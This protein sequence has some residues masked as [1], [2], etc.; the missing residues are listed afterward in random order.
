MA[1]LEVDKLTMR[2]GGLTAISQVD[3]RVEP[4]QIVSVIGPNGAGKTTVFNVITGIYEPSEGNIKLNGKEEGL[5]V[6]GRRL[7]AWLLMGLATGLVVMLFSV[8]ID[9]LWKAT[10]RRNMEDPQKFAWS[11]AWHDFKAYLLGGLDLEKQRGRWRV[12]AA[13]GDPV[14]AT[15]KTEQ[16]ARE[17]L[18]RLESIL[19]LGKFRDH[20]HEFQG[21][22]QV[23]KAMNG[24]IL[25]EYPS[26]EAAE[27]ELQMLAEVQQEQIG[28]RRVA[29]FSFLGGTLLGSMAGFVYWRQTRRTPEVIALA[30]IA[31][32]F[33][34]IRLFQNMSVLENVLTGRD[35]YFKS[36]LWGMVRGALGLRGEERAAVTESL[37]LLTFVGLARKANELAKNLPYGDQRRLEIARALATRPKLLLLDE[38]AAGMNPAE[39]GSLMALIGKIR[40][41]GITILLIE[42]HMSLVMAISDRIAV[43]DHGVKIAEG[44][45]EEV[46][47][48]PKVI[49]AY[50]GKEETE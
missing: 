19:D 3:L 23:L 34:N 17:S 39:T 42:H 45:P 13:D 14:L 36:G 8:N 29:L 4:G 28:R 31:R 1:L 24:P 49:A 10:I 30:G 33:Q 35:R 43:L 41:R 12:V 25:A 15:A 27:A 26:K 6:T 11:E 44:T 21:K 48:N 32:T 7:L 16:E 37:E 18:E 2:F 38:P 46:R 5:P 40:G 47:N 50:L 22:W 20:L 9:K